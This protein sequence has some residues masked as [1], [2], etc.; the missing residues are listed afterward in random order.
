MNRSPSSIILQL[1][2]PPTGGVPRILAS[3]LKQL[4]PAAAVEIADRTGPEMRRLVFRAR[5]GRPI[6]AGAFLAICAAIGI[7][8]VDGSS[9]A[10]RAVPA[11]VAWRMVGVGLSIARRLRRQDLRSA[12]KVIGISASTLCRIEAGDAVSVESLLALCRYIGVHPR[13]TW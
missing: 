3:V 10:P 13:T 4:T 7:D 1:D 8:P 5:A 6:N 2:T 11:R 9:R 12:A